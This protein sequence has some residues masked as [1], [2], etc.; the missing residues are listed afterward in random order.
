MNSHMYY[1]KTN[2][3][4]D[5]KEE[6]PYRSIREDDELDSVFYVDVDVRFECWGN[7]EQRANKIVKKWKE[8]GYEVKYSLFTP[9]RNITF[10]L[11]FE[12][13]D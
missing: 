5:I 12:D 1:T 10:K 3:L 11:Y 6:I 2:F 9:L 13:L 4:N 7:I 8:D